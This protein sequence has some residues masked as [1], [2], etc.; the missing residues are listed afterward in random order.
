MGAYAAWTMTIN[1]GLLT[2]ITDGSFATILR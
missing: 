2:G 1:D